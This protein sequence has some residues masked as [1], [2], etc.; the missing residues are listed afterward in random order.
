[1]YFSADFYEIRYTYEKASSLINSFTSGYDVKSDNV[2]VGDLRNP[3]VANT[4]ESFYIDLA[5]VPL[6]KDLVT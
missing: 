1:M 3:S 5:N 6:N 2:L 4:I